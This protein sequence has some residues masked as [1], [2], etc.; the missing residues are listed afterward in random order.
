MESEGPATA[1][2]ARRPVPLRRAGPSLRADETNEVSGS[3]LLMR[4]RREG[5]RAGWKGRARGRLSLPR[6]TKS[7]FS[8][9]L[10]PV[11]RDALPTPPRRPGRLSSHAPSAVDCVRMR[12]PRASPV[13]RL[14]PGTRRHSTVALGW[15]SLGF[16]PVRRRRAFSFPRPSILSETG[17]AEQGTPEKESNRTQRSGEEDGASFSNGSPAEPRLQR[18]RPFP[19]LNCRR[20]WPASPP[21]PQAEAQRRPAF[22]SSRRAGSRSRGSL[23]GKVSGKARLRAS[24]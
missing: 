23:L 20:T 5:G 15:R 3:G 14:F 12:E 22:P 16:G 6:K 9:L 19:A 10:N 18:C 8:R 11:L 7:C 17:Q 24:T 4:F 21:Q 13:S 2:L 1:A